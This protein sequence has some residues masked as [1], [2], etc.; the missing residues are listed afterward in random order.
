MA[1]REGAWDC[2][3]CGRKRNRGPA[4]HCIGCGYPRGAEVRFYLPE[5][6]PEVADAAALARARSGP[7]WTCTYCDGDNPADADFCSGCGAS[8]DGASPR[9]VIE[10]R[11]EPAAPAPA[12]EAS[13][14]PPKR[15]SSSASSSGCLA[16]C[17]KATA[18]VLAGLGCLGALF[19]AFV[20][21]VGSFLPPPPSPPSGQRAAP[22]EKAE[23]WLEVQ[24]QLDRE[25]KDRQPV[26]RPRAQTPS[27]REGV[28]TVTGFRWTR[29][30]EI[31][32]RVSEVEEAW[33]DDVPYGVQILDRR[34]EVH[35][36][37]REQVGTETKT[38]TWTEREQ[39]GTERVKVGTRDLGNGYF[40]DVYE[41]R[42]VYDD[43]EHSE[44]WEEPV[45]DEVPVVREKVR[46]RTE[47]WDTVRRESARGS[48]RSPR[49]PSVSLASGEREGS[50]SDSY[51]V[52]FQDE[53]GSTCRYDTTESGLSRFEVGQRYR[54]TLRGSCFVVSVGRAL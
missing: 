25:R 27:T 30:I 49:W 39:V 41:D 24:R 51:A 54:A 40:E 38:R 26:E 19:F 17:G 5:D 44:S 22:T 1:I 47:E 46:Y 37:E 2:P 10:Y 34:Q 15:T 6:A 36:H 33:E 12:P 45:Y 43:V 52:V 35:H 28:V 13:S 21:F 14:D 18:A 4:K 42:P 3:H 48:D 29:T 16:G 11:D 8:K 7:D 53:Q 23:E 32:A 50:R 20:V 9:P 31:E